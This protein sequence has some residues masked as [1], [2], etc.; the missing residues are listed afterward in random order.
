MKRKVLIFILIFPT[1]AGCISNTFAPATITPV[2][3]PTFT[4]AEENTPTP[5]STLTPTPYSDDNCVE[6]Q[7]GNLD[8][9]K[10]TGTIVLEDMHYKAYTISSNTFET[11]E[12]AKD[13]EFVFSIAVSPDRQLT[14]SYLYTRNTDA[15]SLVII[16]SSGVTQLSIPWEEEWS[17]I[18]SW[19]DNQRLLINV[20]DKL[21][22]GHPELAAKEFSTFLVV[23]PFTGER[24]LLQP[25]FP[26]IYSHHMF[27]AWIGFGSTVYNAKLDRVVYL[28]GGYFGDDGFFRYVL[29]AIDEQRILADFKIIYQ[30]QDI[31]RWSPDGEKFAI[32]LNLFDEVSNNWPAYNLY[33]VSRDGDVLKLTDLEKHYP[34]L[35]IGQH[36]WSPDGR[37][38]AF[39]LSGWTEQPRPSNLFV[40]QILAVVDTKNNDLSIYCGVSGKFQLN[41]IIPPPIWSPNGKQILIES[42]LPDEHSQVSLLDLNENLI[43]SIAN[44]MTPVGWMIQP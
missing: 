31:P 35:Y 37:Y 11:R 26:E 16:D 20:Y 9:L 34:W 43:V 4:I 30:E 41:G 25:D 28:K 24:A 44:D 14:A 15:S 36:S 29:W 40:D 42:S 7:V 13:G 17:F 3:T 33:T 23:N 19:L 1:I 8:E 21:S 22:D 38:I 10:T 6:V 5:A 12:L 18:S 2:A 27:P 39:W 32:A